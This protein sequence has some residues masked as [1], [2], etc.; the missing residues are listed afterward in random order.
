MF[1]VRT[2]SPRPRFL[3]VFSLCQICAVFVQTGYVLLL[4]AIIG[5]LAAGI[6]GGIWADATN[7]IDS[8]VALGF[9]CFFVGF[10]MVQLIMRVVRS[11]STCRLQYHI[12]SIFRCVCVGVCVCVMLCVCDVVCVCVLCVCLCRLCF[13]LLLGLQIF[14]ANRQ[15]AGKLLMKDT[16]WTGHLCIPRE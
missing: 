4:G 10:F 1:S 7:K 15:T 6:I 3:F 16:S 13:R 14:H 9:I 12:D 8:F 11:Y 5:G 2:P